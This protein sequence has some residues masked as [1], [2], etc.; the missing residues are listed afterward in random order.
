MKAVGAPLHSRA[1]VMFHLWRPTCPQGRFNKGGNMRTKLMHLLLAMSLCGF[2]GCASSKPID[3]ADAGARPA[4]DQHR[5]QQPTVD[6]NQEQTPV[7]TSA[8]QD[9]A[10]D[11]PTNTPK[12]KASN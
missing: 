10:W 2:W 4:V 7:R 11:T 5:E 12:V 8:S 3:S 6:Q 1:S 9:K